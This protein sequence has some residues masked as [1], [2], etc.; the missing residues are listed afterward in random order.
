[1]AFSQLQTRPAFDRGGNGVD[2]LFIF[3]FTI[4]VGSLSFLVLFLLPILY[5][6]FRRLAVP[7]K[8][9]AVCKKIKGRTF[10]LRSVFVV[11]RP[12]L[13]RKQ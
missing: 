5:F 8:L 10:F 9:A 2:I 6:L 4:L 12:L 13:E 1:M 11:A 3:S 7:F